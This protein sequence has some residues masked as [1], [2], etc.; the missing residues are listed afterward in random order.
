MFLYKY[1]VGSF[2]VRFY[3]WVF[4][5]LIHKCVYEGTLMFVEI[6]F[7]EFGR[8]RT[9]KECILSWKIIVLEPEKNEKISGKRSFL[10]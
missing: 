3:K 10:Q 9:I 2:N 1:C 5:T 7:I 8:V 4:F 6:S